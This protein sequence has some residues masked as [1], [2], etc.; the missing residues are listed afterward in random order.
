M[1][2]D[3]RRRYPQQELAERLNDAMKDAEIRP[4][5]VARECG[6]TPQAVHDWQNTGRI[7][8]QHLMTLCRITKKPI[9]YFLVGLGRAAIFALSL[10][11]FYPVPSDAGQTYSGGCGVY[12][13][14]YLI[15]MLYSVLF[16]V[17]NGSKLY[18]NPYIQLG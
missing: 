15:R 6:V 16:A 5:D 10:L 13:V 8:K 4:A 12:Y 11:F 7:G 2:T 18:R 14:K 1:L 9:E 3:M 17:Q